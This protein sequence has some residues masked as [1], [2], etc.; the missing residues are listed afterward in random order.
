ML[1]RKM[2]NIIVFCKA[3]HDAEHMLKKSPKLGL[4]ILINIMLIKKTC[5]SNSYV[6]LPRLHATAVDCAHELING[7]SGIKG[8]ADKINKRG[9][10]NKVGEGGKNGI[11]NKRVVPSIRN[12]RV[13]YINKKDWLIK[14]SR[15][16]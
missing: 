12:L 8:E 2:L 7:E 4:H 6:A 15:N 16:L 9:V 1:P 14:Q 10:L 13:V 3:R 5:T 11:I